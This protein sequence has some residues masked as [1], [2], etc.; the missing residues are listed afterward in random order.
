V[1]NQSILNFQDGITVSA[2]FQPQAL[3]ARES[4]ILSHGSWHNRWKVSIT[5]DAHVRWTLKTAGGVV[6]DID[7]KSVLQVDS[8]Y[9][10]AA[11][12]DGSHLI[13]YLN[14][15][16]EAFRAL[17][18]LINMSPVDFLMGQILPDEPNYN[19]RGVLDELS[20]YDMALSP[21]RI[22]DLAGVVSSTEDIPFNRTEASL[23]TAFPNP[24]QGTI[25]IQ[26]KNRESELLNVHLFD[27][28]T[29]KMLITQALTG[30]TGSIELNG[31]AAGI[32][33]L[34]V[35]SDKARQTITLSIQ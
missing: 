1:S 6:I 24:A 11:T 19:F 22:A 18:G 10:L 31:L 12:Y 27:A 9:H 32:Y 20:I 28:G 29:G 25:S 2:D 21:H 23:V 26:R 4:F 8:I 3:P 14:G 35:I 17:N 15:R 5:P 30:Y 13:L 7:S 34:L 16:M 33:H